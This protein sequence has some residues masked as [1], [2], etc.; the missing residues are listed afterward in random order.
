M[1]TATTES[2]ATVAPA[3][4]APAVKVPTWNTPE[5]Y[6]AKAAEYGFAVSTLAGWHKIE[7]AKGIRC[8]VARTKTVRRID[9]AGFEP[10][11]SFTQVPHVGKFGTVTAQLRLEGYSAAEQMEH[12]VKLMDAMKL[13]APMPVKERKAKAPTSSTPATEGAVPVAAESVASSPEE[14]AAAKAA[15]KALIAK[16]AAEKGV[17]VSAKSV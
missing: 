1:T 15:R 4:A 13:E 10:N 6:L 11:P 3:A 16:V 14:I 12:F 2:T 8:F 5:A 17:E 9:I 7:A